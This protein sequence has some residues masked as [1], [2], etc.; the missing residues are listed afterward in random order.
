M[1][2]DELYDID[3]ELEHQASLRKNAEIERANAFYDGYVKGCDD[4]RKKIAQRIIEE[5]NEEKQQ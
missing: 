5:A 1:T 3:N 4:F 2:L